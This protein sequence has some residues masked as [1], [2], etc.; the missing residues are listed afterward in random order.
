LAYIIFAP[1]VGKRCYSNFSG[2][3]SALSHS[4]LGL[5]TGRARSVFDPTWT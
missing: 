5:S 3:V 1:R 4:K 2:D